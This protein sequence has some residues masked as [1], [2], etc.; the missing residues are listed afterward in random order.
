MATDWTATFIFLAGEKGGSETHPAL[1]LVGTRALSHEGKAAGADHPPPCSAKV[2]NSGAITPLCHTFSCH[3]VELIKH[4]FTFTYKIRYS[5][6]K[7]MTCM[8]EAYMNLNI[9]IYVKIVLDLETV[10]AP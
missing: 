2:K 8:S 7:S 9:I 4:F 5:S 1:C 3:G 6:H 10:D